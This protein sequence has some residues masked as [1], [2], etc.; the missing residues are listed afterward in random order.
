MTQKVTG[1][2]RRLTAWRTS[3]CGTPTRVPA[4][5]A[6]WMRRWR[7]RTLGAAPALRLSGSIRR[8]SPSWTFRGTR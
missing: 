5:M 7:S 6:L 2:R 3:R 4:P 1:G 8:T